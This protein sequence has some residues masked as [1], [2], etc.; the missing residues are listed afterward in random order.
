[1]NLPRL[2][3]LPLCLSLL[4]ATAAAATPVPGR[5]AA[6][7]AA[8]PLTGPCAPGISYHP[9]CDVDHDGDVDIFDIQLAAGHWSQSGPYTSGGWDLTGNAGTDPASN[10][11]GTTDGAALE[12]RVNGYRALRL[13][14]RTDRPNV[15]GGSFGNYVTSGVAG[16]TIAG[17]GAELTFNRVT[18]S[19]GFIGG[20]FGNTAGDNA[21]TVNDNTYQA[22]TGA[23]PTP[24]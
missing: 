24:R 1:M 18:D 10:F 8:Q 19:Y 16:A 13:E 3:V 15:I 20:G 7:V 6:A 12:L 9:A 14:P 17:G 23:P 11:L 4:L 21:G 22:P 5:Q 2:I